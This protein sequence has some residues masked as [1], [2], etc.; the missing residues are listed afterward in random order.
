[1][2]EGAEQTYNRIGEIPEVLR[3]RLLSVRGFDDAGLMVD[4]DVVDGRELEGVIERFFG[5][6][7]MAYLQVH[8]AKRGCYAA[9]IERV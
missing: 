2:R 9:R 3:V 1:V 4:A 7:K 6:P 8:F 5:N